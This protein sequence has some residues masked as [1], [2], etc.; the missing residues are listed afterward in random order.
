M[1]EA[2][3]ADSFGE[4]RG[5]VHAHK[6]AGR[7]V[8]LL[9]F[10]QA[11]HVSYYA[12]VLRR[13]RAQAPEVRPVAMYA[14]QLPTRGLLEAALKDAGFGDL[15]VTDRWEQGAGA[16]L[17]LST[18]QFTPGL[19]DTYS[20]CLF[21][22]QPSKG[23]TFSR[24]ALETYDAYFFYGPLHRQAL[25]RYQ[26]HHGRL[27]D[28]CP[29]IEEAGYPKT[30]PLFDG[31]LSRERVLAGL[32]LPVDATTVLY[33]PAFNEHASLRTAGLDIVRRLAGIRG[34]NVLVKLAGHTVENT[35]K[36][37]STGGVDWPAVLRQFE[38]ERVKLVLDPDVNP[39]LVAAD[40]MLTDVS[41]VAWDFLALDKPV[42]FWDC[43]DFYRKHAVQFDASLSLEECLAD[44]S[45]NAGRNYGTVVSDGDALERA[46]AQHRDGAD[47]MASSRAGL[48]DRILHHRGA[49]TAAVVDALLDLLRQD[50]RPAKP[51]SSWLRD[52][53]LPRTARRIGGPVLRTA[54][55]LAAR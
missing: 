44:D 27:G 35:V 30:D 53:W 40:L 47:P 21:H 19:T 26:R 45:M 49:A 36:G 16:D 46:I 18:N 17:Y 48:A 23:I 12:P 51:H 37:Y 1:S 5:L 4:F 32:G 3:G 29:R 50:A 11:S 22:G 6:R 25:Q 15:P 2:P 42:V 24:R 43:P 41:G 10:P 54:R 20:I 31:S 38:N 33:A 55:R 28:Y 13:L 8:V 34:I 9:E 7:K 14:R 39:C 52:V